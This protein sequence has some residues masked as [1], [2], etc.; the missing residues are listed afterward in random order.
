MGIGIWVG[1]APGPASVGHQQAL[2]VVDRNDDSTSHIPTSRKEPDSE[3]LCRL[4]ADSTLD[5]IRMMV[6]DALKRKWQRRIELSGARVI[7]LDS[8]WRRRCARYGRC[9]AQ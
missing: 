4:G 8:G 5:E 1:L 7:R 9:R 2:F 6:V 3:M